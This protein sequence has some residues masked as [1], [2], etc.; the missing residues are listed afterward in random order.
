MRDLPEFI[1]G[2]HDYIGKALAPVV[3]RIESH[4]S[5]VSEQ[6]VGVSKE[7]IELRAKAE[8]I[9]ARAPE[10]GDKGDNG[11]TL[12]E[13]LPPLLEATRGLVDPVVV[14]MKNEASLLAGELR[15]Q[16]SDV[17]A[18][19]PAVKDGDKGDK[20]DEGKSVTVDEVL[21]VLQPSIDATLAKWETQAERRFFDFCERAIASM[22]KPKDG[23]DGLKLSD[24]TLEFDGKRTYTLTLKDGETAL[25]STV[26]IPA[27]L[28]AG[29]WNE[30]RKFETG[31]VV[32]C[33]GSAWI[34]QKDT[35]TRPEVGNPDWRLAVRKGR[36][37]RHVELPKSEPK[38]VKLG[39]VE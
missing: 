25:Q 18:A 19:I 10:K 8:E 33:A 38:P 17:I 14:E 32:T 6:M 30:G 2:L 22:P 4:A 1:K 20:G 7:L 11:P 12:E 31:D 29:Y 9:E 16:V 15:Q 35:D 39:A 23:A 28:D 5:T 13:L 21:A 36:D 3:A 37:H 24:A 27:I 26:K 34:A